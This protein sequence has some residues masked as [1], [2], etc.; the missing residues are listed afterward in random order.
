MASLI[1]NW[2]LVEAESR[3]LKQSSEQRERKFSEP[4]RCINMWECWSEE[5]CSH[6]FAD[7]FFSSAS[8]HSSDKSKKK[9]EIEAMCSFDGRFISFDFECRC[10]R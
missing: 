8:L 3:I 7:V 10:G 4:L 9:M 6:L 1:L 2:K 5:R